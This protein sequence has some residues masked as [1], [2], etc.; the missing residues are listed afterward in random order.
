MTSTSNLSGNIASWLTDR[1]TTDPDLPAIRQGEQTLSYAELDSAAARFAAVL[2]DHG[3]QPGD[4]VALIMPNVAYFPIAYYAIL[5][6]G[7][8]VVPMN[9]LL[10]AGEI[11]Y[12]WGDS[13]A[14][15][16]VVFASFAEEAGKAASVTE[17]DVI[18][19]AP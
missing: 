14:R 9:P 4:R 10:K 5:R 12:A 2:S 8:I 7:A 19:V 16:A 18:V 3:V 17:T 15:V 6:L 11:S 1:A 13:G